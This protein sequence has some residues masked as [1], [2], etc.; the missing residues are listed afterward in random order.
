MKFIFLYYDFKNIFQRIHIKYFILIF[1]SVLR[2]PFTQ[3]EDKKADW[4]VAVSH[5]LSAQD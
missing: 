5:L 3:T 2:S 4:S 1:S